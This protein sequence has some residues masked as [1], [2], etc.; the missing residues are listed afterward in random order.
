M[1]CYIGRRC[2]GFKDRGLHCCKR[3]IETRS[4]FTS[5]LLGE[6]AM[7]MERDDGEWEQNK[8]AMTGMYFNS[9][10][11]RDEHMRLSICLIPG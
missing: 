8:E 9:L 4:F 1:K 11:T 6:P 5:E 10:F 2:F 3:V 7:M